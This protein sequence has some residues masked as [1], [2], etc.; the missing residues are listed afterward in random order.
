[1]LS[2][3]IDS[4][5][6]GTRTMYVH[7][8]KGNGECDCLGSSCEPE[9]YADDATVNLPLR[10]W[11][12]VEAMVRQSTRTATA[13]RADGIL[14]VWVNDHLIVDRSN[15]CTLLRP[16]AQLHWS[17]NNYADDI[18]HPSTVVLY[19]DDA[20]IAT[21]RV[22]VAQTRGIVAYLSRL[23]CSLMGSSMC[24]GDVV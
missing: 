12:H 21:T 17:V 4:G 11:F 22:R 14:R 1:M 16:D 7:H 13:V 2:F 9:S 3:N 18:I 5:G 20:A 19:I 15:I 23:V 10:E 6:H 8:H 24:R